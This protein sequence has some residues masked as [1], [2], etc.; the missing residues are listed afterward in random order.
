MEDLIFLF[1]LTV[2]LASLLAG[3]GIWSPRN[4]WMKACAVA[5]ATLLFG[6]GYSSLVAMLSLPK[7]VGFE[8]AHRHLPDATVLAASIREGEAI[9][10]WLGMA[11]VAEPR[12]YV[13]PWDRRVA[14][15]LQ[16]TMD[17]AE[18]NGSGVRMTTPFEPSQ[19]AREPKFYAMPQPAPPAK[20]YGAAPPLVYEPP[21][22]AI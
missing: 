6:A 12:A 1:A 10:L 20:D 3:I 16:S 13:L 2:V 7:P 5:T 22:T 8:W 11:G 21:D 9:Y 17:E 19:D 4:Y 18:A 15:Q 14:E